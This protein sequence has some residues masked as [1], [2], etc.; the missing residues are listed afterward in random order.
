MQTQDAAFWQIMACT[1][2]K[3]KAKFITFV[4]LSLSLFFFKLYS[5]YSRA[6]SRYINNNHGFIFKLLFEKTGTSVYTH[7]ET[8]TH[9]I[10]SIVLQFQILLWLQTFFIQLLVN[11]FLPDKHC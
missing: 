4:S 7:T 9:F 11:A 8:H 6:L 1:A 5:N 3:H 2:P 10:H